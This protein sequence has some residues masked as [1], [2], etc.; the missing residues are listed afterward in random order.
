LYADLHRALPMLVAVGNAAPR[1]TLREV[2]GELVR[3]ITLYRSNL[4]HP[5]CWDRSEVL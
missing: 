3:K 1:A 4:G 5:P 2:C